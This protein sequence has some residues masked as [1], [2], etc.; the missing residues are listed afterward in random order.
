MARKIIDMQINLLADRKEFARTAKLRLDRARTTRAP[1]HSM[2]DLFRLLV[3]FIS[4]T[5]AV[6]AFDR[7]DQRR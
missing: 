2:T 5:D 4:N 3:Q 6:T 1:A 7:L